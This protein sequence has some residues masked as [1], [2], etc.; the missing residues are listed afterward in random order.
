[1]KSCLKRHRQVIVSRI[2]A[3]L[4]ESCQLKQ[5]A[6][7]FCG[8]E[9]RSFR[10]MKVLLLFCQFRFRVVWVFEKDSPKTEI[11]QKKKF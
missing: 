7:D 3:T 2:V 6:K 9:D 10:Q 5:S 11:A 8:P 4:I 1:M